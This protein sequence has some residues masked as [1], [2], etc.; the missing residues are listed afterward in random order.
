LSDA[1]A[2]RE[3]DPQIQPYDVI[4]VRTI[5]EFKQVLRI[6]I[7]G[8]VR[9]PGSYTFNRGEKLSQVIK[10]AGGLT[11]LAHTE[12]A[13]FTREDIRQ[14]EAKQIKELRERLRTDVAFSALEKVNGLD[15]SGLNQ[16]IAILDKLDSSQALGRLVIDLK[17]I[18][19]KKLD[20]IALKDQDQLIIPEYQQAVTV[21]GEV[22]RP[23]THLYDRQNNANDYIDLSGGVKRK[24]DE[25]GIYV[26]KA[27]GSVALLGRP[28]WFKYRSTNIEMGDAIIV[29]LDIDRRRGLEVIGEASSIIYQL[30]LGAAA[31]AI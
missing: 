3:N 25:K 8:E 31:V 15:S 27:N 13:I 4:S 26:V 2:S 19:D 16:S 30:A 20:D 28:G 10:R 17:G 23:A 5:P 24:A 14:Q 9:F 29:P 18:L 6:K 22:Q 1:L 21:V 11:S 7:S 12:A